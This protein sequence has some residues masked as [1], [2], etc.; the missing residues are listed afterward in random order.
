MGL[1]DTHSHVYVE[2]FD[3]DRKSCL[4]EA[5]LS[6]IEK[7]LLPNIDIQSI[8]PMHALCDQYPDFAHPMM[9]L[10]PTSVKEDHTQLLKSMESCLH[11][12][13]YCA[14]GE[15]GIDLYWDK[16]HLREQ[17]AAFEEQLQWSID[18][19]LPVMI[20]T[21]KAFPEVFESIHKIGKERLKGVFHSFSGTEVDLREIERLGNFK[22]GI[23]GVITYKGAKLPEIIAHTDI[24]RILLETDSPYL[25]PVPYRGKRNDPVFIWET[26]R[27]VADVFSM[28]TEEVVRITRENVLEMFAL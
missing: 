4:H 14:I 15:I 10:H 16:S 21:R 25:P 28:T 11:K 6:G 3:A 1:V 19:G 27:K 26:A 23:G 12:R 20:H 24:N 13:S 2:A 22:L 7:I 9:G 17:K 5:K 18:L 8:A